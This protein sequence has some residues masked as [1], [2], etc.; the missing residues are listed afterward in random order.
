MKGDSQISP[1]GGR[2]RNCEL[3]HRGAVKHPAP[4]L[5]LADPLEGIAHG[6]DPAQ[7]GNPAEAYRV[8]GDEKVAA[9]ITRG[10][11]RAGERCGGDGGWAQNMWAGVQGACLFDGLASWIISIQRKCFL[12]VKGRTLPHTPKPSQLGRKNPVVY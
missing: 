1:T 5:N 7:L 11:D 8:K 12:R 2:K 3:T 4:Q 9:R 10:T 6:A